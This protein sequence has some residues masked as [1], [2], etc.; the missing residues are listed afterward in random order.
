MSAANPKGIRVAFVIRPLLHESLARRVLRPTACAGLMA[1][2]LLT[3]APSM[4]Q[5]ANI[6]EAISPIPL[7]HNLDP[8]KIGLG[9]MLF[10]DSRLSAGNGVACAS[11]HFPQFN[12]IDGVPLSR[13]L[14]GAPG[15]TNT[16]TL[17]NVGLNPLIGWAGK[18]TTLEEHAKTV[19]EGSNTMGAKWEDVIAAL[20]N[21]QSMVDQFNS[22]YDSG[23]TRNNII[24]A[25]VAYERSLVTPNAPFDRYLR[26]DE[27]AINDRAKAGYQLFKDLGCISCHQGENVGGNMFQVFGIFGQ[28]NVV[29]Q[30]AKTPGSAQNTGIDET[31]P[32]FR[33][34]SLRNVAKTAPY[35]HDGSVPTLT[36]AI[37]IMATRQLGR[38]IPDEEIDKL[39]T[40]LES[41]TGEYEGVPVGE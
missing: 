23:I 2:L 12:L 40:F 17:Y 3:A 30:G 41:L 31:K 25:L 22:I 27:D 13:G 7:E 38:S 4:A 6:E 9:K 39:K 16:P 24:N 20:A 14:P 1:S 21:D 8:K 11:C 15:V 37:N 28:S 5:G 34:P 35:F 29:L 26:G 36:S 19:V 18:S 32:V 10:S 33:V